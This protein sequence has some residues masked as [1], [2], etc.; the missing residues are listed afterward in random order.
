MSYSM[1]LVGWLWL[2][3][4]TNDTKATSNEKGFSV[5]GVIIAIESI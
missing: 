2:S 5:W 4:W 1:D 3:Y